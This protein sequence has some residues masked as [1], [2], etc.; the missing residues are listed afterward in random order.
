MKSKYGRL[1]FL[2]V[3]LAAGVSAFLS[4]RKKAHKEEWLQKV[5]AQI[6]DQLPA[7]LIPGI[8]TEK[9]SINSDL[10]LIFS[11]KLL[12]LDTSAETS[13]FV[14]S[15]LIS[16]LKEKFCTSPAFSVFLEESVNVELR[17]SDRTGKHV[18]TEQLSQKTCGG[19]LTNG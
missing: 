19:G 6:N 11:Y 7:E 3:V 12:A 1:I 10:Q 2:S 15:Q 18:T 5:S 17:I 14:S 16:P 13:E 9:T 4:E 8:M